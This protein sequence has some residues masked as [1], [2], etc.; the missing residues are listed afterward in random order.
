L[1]NPRKFNQPSHKFSS[2]VTLKYKPT[3]NY[4]RS[5]GHISHPNIV[6][7]FSY[8][9]LSFTVERTAR[10]IVR[11]A[12]VAQ[13]ISRQDLQAAH[14]RLEEVALCF[15]RRTIDERATQCQK[16]KKIYIIDRGTQR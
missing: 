12:H 15:Q 16:V 11:S 3:R 6:L 8:S 2:F 10:N 1:K 13:R 5:L 14:R 4:G 9:F 7:F